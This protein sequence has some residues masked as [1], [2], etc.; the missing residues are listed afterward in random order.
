MKH[1]QQFPNQQLLPDLFHLQ[2]R[3]PFLSAT[4]RHDNFFTSKQQ[5]LK[6]R[7]TTTLPPQQRD[8][9][10]NRHPLYTA[11]QSRH[12][13]LQIQSYKKS[14]ELKSLT[15]NPTHVHLTKIQQNNKP[16]Q[17]RKLKKP[18]AIAQPH[19]F[20]AKKRCT[21]TGTPLPPRLTA[22]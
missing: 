14:Y 1:A 12:K 11:R 5:Q 17:G 2:L 4:Q 8:R 9:Q 7:I 13:E 19:K 18:Y 10:A 6:E 22:S 15:K 3:P 21:V 20:Y 16:Q